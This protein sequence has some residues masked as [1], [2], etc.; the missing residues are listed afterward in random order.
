MDPDLVKALNTLLFPTGTAAEIIEVA[1]GKVDEV[2]G[3]LSKSSMGFA[4]GSTG[5][6]H[7]PG[8]VGHLDNP[9]LALGMAGGALSIIGNLFG[10]IRQIGAATT[11]EQ[12][13]KLL[14]PQLE[15]MGKM[16]HADASRLG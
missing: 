3:V 15:E 7:V 4:A 5:I 6:K 10:I 2:V 14:A 9:L 16:V 1:K 13:K 11:T 12:I 8:V